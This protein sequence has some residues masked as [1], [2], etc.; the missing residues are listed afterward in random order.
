MRRLGGWFLSDSDSGELF[1]DQDGTG[2]GDAVGIADLL[3]APSPPRPD[4]TLTGACEDSTGLAA[5]PSGAVV[6]V[7]SATAAFR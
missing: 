7:P 5:A 2:L 4:P 1:W 6:L 3:S